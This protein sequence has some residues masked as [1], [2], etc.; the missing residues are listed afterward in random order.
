MRVKVQR[1]WALCAML[2]LLVLGVT[3]C[4]KPPVTPV[5]DGFRCRVSLDYGG[6]LYEATL[7][8]LAESQATLTLTKPEALKGLTMAWDG[9]AVSM[10]Y[11][12][13]TMSFE[14][15]SLPVGAAVK[16]LYRTLDAC[17][18]SAQA[19]SVYEGTVDGVPYTVSFDDRTGLPLSLS[20]PS[21]PIHAAF[22]E[23]EQPNE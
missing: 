15:A 2:W 23:W 22:S 4:A 7:D 20:V 19:N 11:A 16:I 17:R 9:Q 13:M 18:E 21:I 8:R 10:T 12:G 5:T 14:D 1:V 3:A 6:A